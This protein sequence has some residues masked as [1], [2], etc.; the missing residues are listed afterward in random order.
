MTTE[1]KIASITGS[2]INLEKKKLK[3]CELTLFLVA[4]NEHGA[5]IEIPFDAEKGLTIK[6]NIKGGTR[7][8]QQ[9]AGNMLVKANHIESLIARDQIHVD[10]YRVGTLIA[11]QTTLG[12]TR[13]IGAC[14]AGCLGAHVNDQQRKIT[15]RKSTRNPF[16]EEH[17]LEIGPRLRHDVEQFKNLSGDDKT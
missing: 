8:I 3:G 5:A 16:D 7:Q 14:Y 2:V 4:R 10:S 6:L 12:S 1:Q 9:F 15:I 11:K 13:E 17:A